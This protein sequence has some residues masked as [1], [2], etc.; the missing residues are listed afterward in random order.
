[1]PHRHGVPNLSTPIYTPATMGSLYW[2]SSC[3]LLYTEEGF[4]EIIRLPRCAT[5]RQSFDHCM[6]V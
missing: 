1:M 6:S 4:V 2:S 5:S 3:W